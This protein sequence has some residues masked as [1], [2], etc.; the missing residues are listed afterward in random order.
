LYVRENGRNFRLG[1]LISWAK[2]SVKELLLLRFRQS[3]TSKP[4]AFNAFEIN[5]CIVK[6][7][8]QKQRRRIGRIPIHKGRTLLRSVRLNSSAITIPTFIVLHRLRSR[9]PIVIEGYRAFNKGVIAIISWSSEPAP[10]AS[11]AGSITVALPSHPV[12]ESA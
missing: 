4:T 5:S 11:I 2:A 6:G 1:F 7:I 8:I 12:R 9:T 3:G 10:A